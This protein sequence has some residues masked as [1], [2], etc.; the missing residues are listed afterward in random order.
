MEAPGDL[1]AL[2]AILAD[3]PEIADR[4]GLLFNSRLT[5]PAYD[6]TPRNCV[7]FAGTGGDGVHYSFLLFGHAPADA[8]PIVMT[9][10]M[11]EEPNRV[12]GRNLR[13]FL[14]LGLHS[15]YFMLEQLQYDFAGTVAA[16]DRHELDYREPE[17]AR[18]LATIAEALQVA[19]WSDH[20]S[21]LARLEAEYAGELDISQGE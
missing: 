12:L 4:L 6:Q 7:T 10:P 20:A 17:E 19:G 13:H 9:V 18:A 11:A 2:K 21:E 15:G 5:G 14:G 8:S 3:I 1:V 16:L